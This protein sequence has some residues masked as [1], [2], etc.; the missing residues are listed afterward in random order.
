MVDHD[1]VEV[2]VILGARGDAR[3][4]GRNMIHTAKFP[5]RSRALVCYGAEMSRAILAISIFL[6]GSTPALGK[7]AAKPAPT[8]PRETWETLSGHV[9]EA[10]LANG[11]AVGKLVGVKGYMATI[12]QG[13]GTVRTVDIRRVRKLKVELDEPL[14]VRPAQEPTSEPTTIYRSEDEREKALSDRYE[15]QKGIGMYA[16][17]VTL[18]VIGSLSTASSLIGILATHDPMFTAGLVPGLAHLAVG[19]PL[20][21]VGGKRRDRYRA[22]L[23]TASGRP[24]VLPMASA[25]RFGWSVGL[26]IRF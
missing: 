20:T 15:G 23:E 10:E 19:I 14:P 5:N 7:T 16:T 2:A 21:V 18:V 25:S 12:V 6:L 3:D 13:D 26:Q 22:W 1:R 24:R 9:V 11:A 8:V 4:Q 17:G